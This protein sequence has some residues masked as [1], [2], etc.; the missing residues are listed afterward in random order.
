MAASPQFDRYGW[1]VDD[2]TTSYA[3]A[4]CVTLVVGVAPDEAASL[5][6]ADLAREMP[7]GEVQRDDAM[8]WVSVVAV[9]QVSPDAGAVLIED[10]GWEGSRAEVLAALSKKGAAASVFWNVNGVVR[11]ACARRGKAL[12]SVELPDPEDIEGLP[13]T[14][15]RL[16]QRAPDEAHPVSV[17]ALMAEHFTGVPLRPESEVVQP[18]TALPITSPVLGL[19]V[20]PEELVG[21]EYPSPEVVRAVQSASPVQRRSLA[22]WSARKALA[23]AGLESHPDVSPVLGEF[24][25][26]ERARMTVE[27]SALRRAVTARGSGDRPAPKYWALNALTYTAVDDSVTAALG[28]TY[29]CG[30]MYV[31]GGEA[32]HQYLIE[33]VSVLEG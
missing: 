29:C 12:T 17:A 28:A 11:F 24:G 5:V 19:P 33:A 27:V 4:G 7:F 30:V 32:Y 15:R 26:A 1:L 21:L 25:R 10:N 13:S 9:D 31:R 16:L 6:G 8:S 14:L 3:V 20:T 22:E 23:L 18:V 2:S